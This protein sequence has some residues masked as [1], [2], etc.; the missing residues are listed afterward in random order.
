VLEGWE[1]GVGNIILSSCN[2]FSMYCPLRDAVEA[3]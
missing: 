1:E 3:Y 2:G